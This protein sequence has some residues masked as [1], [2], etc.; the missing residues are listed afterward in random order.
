MFEDK[1]VF[2]IG[3]GASAEFGLP[4]GLK[5]L[6]NIKEN[7]LFEFEYGNNPSKGN[8]V[9]FDAIVSRYG[10]QATFKEVF[11]T[12]GDIARG[13]ETAGSI[14]EY[15]NRYSDDEMIAELGKLLISYSILE[16]ERKSTMMATARVS[17]QPVNWESTNKTWIAQFARILFD[18]VKANAIERIGEGLT[19]ICFNY[20]RCIEYY[21]EHAVMRAYRGV[22]QKTARNIVS[23]IEILHP[24]GSLG[25]LGQIRF[26]AP[27]ETAN[28]YEIS[29]NLITW[30]ESI[31]DRQ[32]QLERIRGHISEAKNLVFLG[33]AFANQNMKLL[34]PNATQL[35]SRYVD[36]Y[37]TGYGLTDDIEVKL[38]TKLMRWFGRSAPDLQ[39][40][41]IKIK[42]DMACE[43]FLRKQAL[44]LTA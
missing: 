15:I 28:L 40:N 3:A 11:K 33:F 13:V 41:R 38:K 29:Q 24:Y 22:D 39:G 9:V 23:R 14:D 20:D 37:S 6:E 35:N 34:D 18:G 5:L 7:S 19:V 1:T 2:V 30:S 10:S 36:I 32:P 21:L 27:P 17:Q 25:H 44:N 31:E 42:Y 26:G 16:A 43:E 8:R 12:L 4:V